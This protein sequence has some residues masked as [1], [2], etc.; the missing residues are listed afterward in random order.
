MVES[1][2]ISGIFSFL[3]EG[4]EETGMYNTTVLKDAKH[5]GYLNQFGF[6]ASVQNLHTKLN[7][8]SLNV[9]GS[10]K[11]PGYHVL[12]GKESCPQEGSWDTLCVFFW[13]NWHLGRS[14]VS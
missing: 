14:V 3:K 12:E 1:D 6:S 13:P 10:K 4:Q 5:S 9:K 11:M 7:Y 8:V 2:N